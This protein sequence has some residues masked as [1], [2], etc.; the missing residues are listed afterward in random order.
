MTTPPAF[1]AHVA[2]VQ[3]ALTAAGLLADVGRKPGN[4][5]TLSDGRTPQRAYAV[6][7]PIVTQ[8]DGPVADADA[9]YALTVQVTCHA[10]S[11]DAV[12]QLVDDVEVAL[13]ALVVAGRSVTRVEPVGGGDLRRD[14]DVTPPLYYATPRWQMHTTPT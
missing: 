8:R 7:F 6:I 9:D 12:A 2:G 5:P 14:D 13:R 11:A 3:S 1:A 10:A 4:V